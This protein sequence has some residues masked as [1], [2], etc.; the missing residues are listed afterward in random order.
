MRVR[1]GACLASLLTAAFL[2]A[3]AG[4][5]A[6]Q[7]LAPAGL[8]KIKGATAYVKS[9]R[10]T[11][12]GF[13]F[14]RQSNNTGYV[15]TCQ[16]V[17]EGDPTVLVIFGSGTPEQKEYEGSVIAT[18]P[19]RDLASVMIRDTKRLPNPL[20]IG[21]KSSGVKEK[22]IVY[23]AG[24][25]FGELLADRKTNP[26]ITLSRVSVSGL[27]WNSDGT[28]QAVQLLGDINPGNSGGPVVN[29]AGVVIGVTQSG[30]RG[31]RTAFAVPPEEIQGFLKGRVKSVNFRR[32]AQ[33]PTLTRVEVHADLVDPIGSMRGAG[34]A[35]GRWEDYSRATLKPD[36]QLTL[37]SV[38]PAK[39][40]VSLKINNGV[41]TGSFE[42]RKTK[43]DTASRT[44][45]FQMTYTR[46][47]G[48]VHYT[49]PSSLSI[50]FGLTDNVPIFGTGADPTA[51]PPA[52]EP[53]PARLPPLPT[54]EQFKTL[55][56]LKLNAVVS[57]LFLSSN[58][59]HLYALDLSEAKVLKID[60]SSMTVAAAADVVENAVA[61]CLRP[62]EKALYVAGRDPLA[63][64]SETAKGRGT[65]QT[66][67]PTTLRVTQSFALDAAPFD[68]EATDKGLIF[69]S[70]LSPLQG[71]VTVD[72]TNKLIIDTYRRFPST[73]IHLT[74]DQSR[75]YLTS[76]PRGDYPSS[77]YY[78]DG[79]YC[80]LIGQGPNAVHEAQRQEQTIGG[81]FAITPDGRHLVALGGSVMRLSKTQVVDLRPVAKLEP[82]VAVAIAPGTSTFFIA[83]HTGF[84]KQYELESFQLQKSV[85][86]GK[87]CRSMILDPT[88]KVL[89][90]TVGRAGPERKAGPSVV[91]IAAFSISER[92]P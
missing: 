50:Y 32:V 38:I 60:T 73:M 75:L 48:S 46:S 87:A 34:L 20:D 92:D 81:D 54:S 12:S 47:D 2:L 44:L 77:Y 16:H 40:T 23:S 67:D 51:P 83:T 39:T 65:L 21:Q 30:I 13:L 45:V 35:Y 58:G 59:K 29:A 4:A 49:E 26:E 71:L 9:R 3:P 11:G 33:S 41:A 76:A 80:V 36:K 78:N 42:V 90:A 24:F 14:L 19:D 57:D 85:N 18:D 89:Y 84:V 68:L 25:P 63:A 28:V 15:I 52:P 43:D 74:P 64:A 22:Q 70:T 31:I 88:R 72:T 86:L 37:G 53:A 1:R 10:G 61:M 17:V 7:D 82:S 69:M 91:D 6:Q 8:E 5:A 62:D 55:A 79:P 27:R 66:L 56:T